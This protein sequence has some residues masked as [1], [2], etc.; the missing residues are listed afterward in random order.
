M[1]LDLNSPIIYLIT[2][3]EATPVNFDDASRQ[4]LDI[5]RVAVEEKI[6]LVQIREK[7]LTAKLL[8]ELTAKVVEITKGS[9]TRVLVNDRADIAI[10]SGA[11]GVHLTSKSLSAEVIRKKFGSGFII[12]VSNHNAVEADAAFAGGADFIVFGPVFT[13]PGKGSASGLAELSNVCDKLKPFPVIALGG[14]DKGNYRSVIYAGAKG[15]AAIRYLNDADKL[16]AIATELR[17]EK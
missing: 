3:G 16:R 8:F 1:S 17:N 5:V 12:G 4:I 10:A 2:K 13:T 7:H 11:D 15:F 9:A 14:V 6:P